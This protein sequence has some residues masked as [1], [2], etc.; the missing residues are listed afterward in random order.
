VNSEPWDGAAFTASPADIIRA[1]AT[2]QGK[3]GDDVIVLLAEA[4]YSYDE[5]GRET[6]VRRFVYLIR[7]PG[8]HESWSTVQEDWAPWHRS[9]PEVRARVITP[10]GAEHHLDPSTLTENAIAESAPDMFED[11]RVLRAPLPATRPGAVVEQ[12]VT[13]RD[14][15]PFFDGGVV[16][17]TASIPV[18]PCATPG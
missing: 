16:R 15:A 14:T 17:F 18:S 13:V 11:D 4:S 5:A 9:R 3:E 7:T 12:Q 6:Y 2:V 8:A 1:A 10:D